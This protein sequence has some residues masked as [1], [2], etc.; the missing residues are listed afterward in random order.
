[1]LAW[2]IVAAPTDDLPG[3]A[4]WDEYHLV[5]GMDWSTWRRLGE[6]PRNLEISD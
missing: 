6:I 4:G 5:T 3:D 1:M 2:R